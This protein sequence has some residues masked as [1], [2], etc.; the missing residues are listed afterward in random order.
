MSELDVEIE[1]PLV[2]ICVPTFNAERTIRETIASI[3]NQNYN[4]LDIHIVDNASTD[5]TLKILSEF[6]DSRIT[7]HRNEVNI[8]GEGNFNR[9]IQLATGK[10]TAIYHADDVYEPDMVG[11]EVAFL[12]ANPEA[13]AVFTEANLINEMGEKFGVLKMPKEISNSSGL[14]DLNELFLITLY[15]R[16]FFVCPSAMVKTILYKNLIKQWRGELFKSSADL[17]VWFRIAQQHPVGFIFA[18][19][20]KYRISKYQF[21][22][23][24]RSLTERADFFL[25]MDFYLENPDIKKIVTDLDRLHYKWIERTD[26]VRR[27]INLFLTDR[28]A[29]ANLLCDDILSLDAFRAAMDNRLGLLSFFAGV[30]IKACNFLGIQVVGKRLFKLFNM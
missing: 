8:G 11:K 5:S 16:T 18:P 10:Y 22:A 28:A 9:C 4:H 27:A 15:R 24:N 14:F 25:V 23:I 13:G 20:M 12:E 26:R 7:I 17:D 30:Y 19:L 1:T 3:L 29:E 2:C 6:V 21:S